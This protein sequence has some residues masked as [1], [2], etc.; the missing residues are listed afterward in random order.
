MPIFSVSVLPTIHRP[1]GLNL[2]NLS[3]SLVL[4]RM[5]TATGAD[6]SSTVYSPSTGGQELSLILISQLDSVDE[7]RDGYF[8][9]SMVI[10]SGGMQY[11]HPKHGY[12]CG[13][14]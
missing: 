2:A 13:S 6:L 8:A 12:A 3:S 11:L 10:A 1:A 4:A 14:S 5:E 7:A 9:V